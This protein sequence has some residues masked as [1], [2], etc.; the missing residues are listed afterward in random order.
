MTPS[1]S[2]MEATMTAWYGVSPSLADPAARPSP[3][4][5]VSNRSIMSVS[6]WRS[7]SPGTTT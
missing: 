2:T 3:S 6:S 1:F 4:A 5:T 7:V